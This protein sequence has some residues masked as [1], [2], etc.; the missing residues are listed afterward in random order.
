[1]LAPTWISRASATQRAGRTG[2]GKIEWDPLK[3]FLLFIV[4]HYVY[5]IIFFFPPSVRKGTVYR[6]YSRNAFKTYM[7]PFDQGELVRSPLDNTI[8][9]LRDMLD[10]SVTPI[11]LECLE[12]PDISTIERSFQSLHASNFI[13]EATDDGLITSLGSLVVALGIDLTLGAFVGLGIQFGVAAEAIQIA[14]ILSF[15][16]P[17]WAI[18]SPIYHDT[19]TF[20]EIVRKTFVSRCFFDAG[21][22]S[23]PLAISNLLHDYSNCKNKNQFCWK[24]SVSATRIRHLYGTVE[25]LK[26]RVAERLNVSVEVLE[27]NNPPYLMDHASEFFDA[28]WFY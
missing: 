23:E 11:L 9:S 25:S 18:S 28:Y 4:L 6:L 15:P 22:F 1:M 16:K 2:R 5:S 17:P 19:L 7:Q 20:N 8:L 3:F 14:A 10:E 13:S 27:V 26:R 21:L 12:P 24:H